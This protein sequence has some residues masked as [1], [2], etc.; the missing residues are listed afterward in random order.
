MHAFNETDAALARYI[1]DVQLGGAV[2]QRRTGRLADSVSPI[3]AVSAGGVVTGGVI[4]D[5]ELAPYGRFH[6]YGAQVPRRY[7]NPLMRWIGVEGSPIFRA[8]AK[9][10]TLPVRSFMR[11]ALEEYMPVYEAA[12]IVAIREGLT[13]E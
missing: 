1:K 5:S 11:S 10:F 7:G 13:G 3:P 12:V 4:Q 9:G 2:L 6:E 8:T